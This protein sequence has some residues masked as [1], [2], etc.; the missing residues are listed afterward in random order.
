VKAQYPNFPQ[1]YTAGKAKYTT[2]PIALRSFEKYADTR[3][4]LNRDLNATSYNDG[5]EL[6]ATGK[7]VHWPMTT[8]VLTNIYDLYPDQIEDI[9]VFGQP[10]DDPN[11]HGLTVW[12]AGGL[13][14]YKNSKN[15]ELAK[16]FTSFTISEEGLKTSWAVLKPDG[17]V[18]VKGISL[19][20]NVYG[21]VKDM[22]PYFNTGKTAPALEFESPVKGPIL[23]E[24]CVE[25]GSGN[26]SPRE[27]AVAY[28]ADVQKQAVQLNLPGW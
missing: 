20:D 9:G 7:G 1:D 4:Y 2:T 24:I 17:P 5:M 6:L 27:A 25:V 22:M 26:I 18:H 10:G 14:I 19:P 8:N 23:S 21:G 3:T 11:N 13:Y 12:A 15:I 16:Q 28:D